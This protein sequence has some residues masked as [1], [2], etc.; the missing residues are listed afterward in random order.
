MYEQEKYYVKFM[1]FFILVCFEQSFNKRV[2]LLLSNLKSMTLHQLILLK[3]LNHKP[4]R[5]AQQNGI[6]CPP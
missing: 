5:I 2:F 6:E 3:M 4:L 1:F